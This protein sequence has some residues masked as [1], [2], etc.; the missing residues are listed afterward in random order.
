ME[1]VSA[2]GVESGRWQGTVL[3]ASKSNEIPAARELLKKVDIEGKTVIADAI[4][5]QFET[6]RQIVMEGGGQYIL[7]VKGNQKQLRENIERRLTES[8]VPPS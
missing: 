8:P 6:A 2:F 4:H 3:T 5:T 1:L 7:T